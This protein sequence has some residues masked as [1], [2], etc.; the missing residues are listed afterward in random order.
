MCNEP[1]STTYSAPLSKSFWGDEN[2]TKPSDG[3]LANN[4]GKEK[5]IV[6]EEVRLQT[7]SPRPLGEVSVNTFNRRKRFH[8]ALR[9][10]VPS[11]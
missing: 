2:S 8:G 5:A 1:I 4:P 11:Y 6:S 7:S 3:L 9:C 10:Y